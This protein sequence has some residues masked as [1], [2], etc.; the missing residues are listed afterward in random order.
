MT[1]PKIDI[2]FIV[3]VVF[4]IYMAKT[5]AINFRANLF[6]KRQML[7][8]INRNGLLL[9]YRSDQAEGQEFERPSLKKDDKKYQK[10]NFYNQM[11]TVPYSLVPQRRNPRKLKFFRPNGIL[12]WRSTRQI[13]RN[14]LDKYWRS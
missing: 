7:D 6:L 10:V 9:P 8:E 13:Q 11:R 14:R 3:L 1:R 5:S 12:P 2:F 4:T